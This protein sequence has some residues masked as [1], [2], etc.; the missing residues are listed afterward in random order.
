MGSNTPTDIKAAA[1]AVYGKAVNNDWSDSYIIHTDYLMYNGVQMSNE[2]TRALY[3][4]VAI[5]LLIIILASVF[6]IYDSFAV[7][8]QQRARYLGMLASVGATRTQKRGS[9]YFEG[10]ILGCI[11][12]PIGIL[13]GIGGI[14][15][16]LRALSDS[17]M[18]TVMV[19]TGDSIRLHAVVDWKIIV[20]SA[21]ISA[22]TI[23]ISAWIPA[24]RASKITPIEAL[25]QTNTVKVKKAKKLKTSRLRQKLFGFEDVLAV[26][27]CKRNAKRSRTVVLALAVS[28]ILFLTT[29]N[30]VSY[31]HL[32]LPTKLE[33]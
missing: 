3:G 21:L 8:Y 26:K 7:S 11:G 16:T 5:I 4:F 31:T 1:K 22:L 18:K 9:V 6:M 27:N 15:V 10:F 33:V 14:A 20:F 2:I 23:F 32:T 28:V 25:R 13:C 24:H 29:T 12:I 17:F 19:A 30:S